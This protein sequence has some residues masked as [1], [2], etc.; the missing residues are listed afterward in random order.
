M[1]MFEAKTCPTTTVAERSDVTNSNYKPSSDDD[2]KSALFNDDST[3]SSKKE[4]PSLHSPDDHIRD[5]YMLKPLLLPLYFLETFNYEYRF[6]L[7]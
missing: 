4:S 6:S 1:P 5:V 2:G 3:A 7:F